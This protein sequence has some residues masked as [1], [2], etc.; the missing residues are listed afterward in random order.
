M[1]IDL[2]TQTGAKKGSLE[3][4]TAVFEVPWN[5]GLV[6]QALLRQLGNAR[7]PI[8]FTKTRGE[9]RGGG[10]K[11]WKQ[12][13]T[14]RARAGSRRSPLWHKGGVTFGPRGVEN[15]TTSM[16]KKQRT[17]ALF[18]VLSQKARD[19][20]LIAV[21]D[22]VL[23]KPQTKLVSTL[24]KKLPQARSY[25]LVL[26]ERN[27]HLEKSARN[28]ASV[29]VIHAP[30]LNIADLLKYKTIVGLADTF[31]KIDEVWGKEATALSKS[32]SR[33]TKK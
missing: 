12:K 20:E 22:F 5:P 6:H 31:K 15:Y 18:S 21:E 7:H 8:A 1:K 27:D 28:M 16:T 29:K 33:T 10:K 30:Y 25:L 14:G 4:N 17:L 2:Y 13:H 19:S 3:L 32:R 9:R 23:E 24:F 26:P 11:P